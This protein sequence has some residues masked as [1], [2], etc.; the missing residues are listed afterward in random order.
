MEHQIVDFVAELKKNEE[1]YLTE[2]SPRIVAGFVR[3]AK[4]AARMELRSI[5]EQKDVNL[6]KD[7]V[8]ESLD[9]A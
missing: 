7:I 4:A 5:V 8:R 9:I 6:V 2:I 1:R 3:M